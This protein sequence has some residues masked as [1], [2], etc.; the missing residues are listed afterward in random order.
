MRLIGRFILGLALLLVVV[1][2]GLYLLRAPAAGLVLRYAF[3]RAGVE[4]PRLKIEKISLHSL[5][6]TSLAAGADPAEPDVSITAI[7]VDFDWRTLIGAHRVGRIHVGSGRITARIDDNNRISIAGLDFGGGEGGQAKSARSP[8]DSVDLDGFDL[9]LAGPRGGAAG[10]LSGAFGMEEGGSFS[11]HLDTERYGTD[12][13]A[14]ENAKFDGDF[15]LDPD[16]DAT[17]S[18]DLTGDLAASAGTVRGVDVAMNAQG[19]SWR[20]ALG[21]DAGKVR[22]EATFDIRSADLATTDA[23]AL[24]GFAAGDAR[25]LPGGPVSLL[26]IRGRAR[27]TYEDGRFALY[28]VDAAPL[29]ITADN[30]ANL[31]LADLDGAPIYLQDGAHAKAAFGMALAGGDLSADARF[32]AETGEDGA[33][34]FDAD[35]AVDNYDSEFADLG[36]TQFVAN[37]TMLDKSV[38]ADIAMQTAVRRASFGDLTV[39][40]ADIDA[41]FHLAMNLADKRAQIDIAADACLRLDRARVIFGRQQNADLEEAELCP[42]SAPLIIADWSGATHADL[43]GVL[44]A[45][46]AQYR[47]GQTVFEG[48]P[49]RIDFSAG[50][51]GERRDTAVTGRLSG[52]RVVVNDVL[53]LAGMK[54]TFEGRLDGDGLTAESHL[55][56]MRISQA[57]AKKQVAPVLASGAASFADDAARF[58]FALATPDGVSLGTGEGAHDLK[59]GKGSAKFDTGRLVFAPDGLQPAKLISPLYGLVRDMTGEGSATAGVQW[60]AKPDDFQSTAE[61]ILD[62]A[63]FVGPS[64][65]VSKTAGLSGTLKFSSLAPLTTDGL[66]TVGIDL[67][68]LDALKLENGEI[69]FEMPGDETLRLHRGEFPWF[70][71]KIGVYDATTSISGK[72]ATA[73]LRATNVD[74]AQ[75]LDYLNVESLSGEGVVEGVLPLVFEDGKARI[76]NGELSAV[77]PG[78]IRYKGEATSAAAASNQGTRIAFDLLR[79]LHFDKLTAKINGPLDG[80][81]DFQIRLEGNNNITVDQKRNPVSAPIIYRISIEAPILALIDQ[82]RVSTNFRLQLERLK[83]QGGLKQ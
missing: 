77:G 82:A 26:S 3:E 83:S 50:Y 28:S 43:A 79:E 81:I 9:T 38:E 49:P 74:L 39:R 12:A 24:A 40:N 76:E 53:V 66:Q 8:F 70:G 35:A 30:D 75:L 51:S 5:R 41:P 16:G 78:V 68:D 63:T 10:R 31:T 45:N 44:S 65:A 48:A 23:P 25:T 4:N 55:Q 15:R 27:A 19:G 34:E 58:S 36:R 80:D 18:G 69:V 64:L 46:A 67:V 32:V 7:D 2:A 20:A 61:I 29:R 21:G 73:P 52:G 54:G 13:L 72:K 56:T 57:G 11:L 59:T 22:G 6:L 17:A 42:A 47:I 33:L 71:G 1:A 62:H 60:G 14:F 37:G